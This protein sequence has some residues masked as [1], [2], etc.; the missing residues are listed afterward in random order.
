MGAHDDRGGGAGDAEKLAAE[1]ADLPEAERYERLIEF[2]TD[3]VFKI[4]GSAEQAFTDAV[5]RALGE[6]GYPEP[7]LSVR[8]S[9]AARYVSISCTVSVESGARLVEIYQALRQVP[10]LRYLL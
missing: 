9:T 3:H 4:I 5:R 7:A 2:P 8:H 10:G 6:L 1:L